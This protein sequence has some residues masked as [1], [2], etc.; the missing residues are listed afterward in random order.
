ML[1][2]PGCFKVKITYIFPNGRRE[3]GSHK[4]FRVF[5]IEL[6]IFACVADSVFLPRR[7]PTP[8]AV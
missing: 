8:H 1:A 6:I 4:Q 3:K 7:P 2:N 5:L